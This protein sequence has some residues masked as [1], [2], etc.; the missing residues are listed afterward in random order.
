MAN[1]DA[2]FQLS[3]AQLRDVRNVWFEQLTR[4]ED[5]ILPEKKHNQH[6]FFGNEAFDRLCVDRF[7]GVLEGIRKSGIRTG[8]DMLE[9]VKPDNP[10]DW[11]SL[12]IL[13]DQIPRNCYRD[14]TAAVA[15]TFFDPMAREVALAAMSQGLPEAIPE[16]RW[17]LAYRKWFYLPFVHSEDL[18][19]HVLATRGF[20]MMQKDVYDLAEE[21]DGAEQLEVSNGHELLETSNGNGQLKASNGH[22]QLDYRARAA[23][24]IQANAAR[25]RSTLDAWVDAEKRHLDI[26][27]RFG[28]YPH[29]NVA[30]G[31]VSTAEEREFLENG[32]ETF[33]RPKATVNVE[34]CGAAEVKN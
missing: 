12:I 14:D 31:R 27:K 20:E 13:L 25:S 1:G 19:A 10:L 7:A 4:P 28:R 9:I 8:D 23:K 18:E 15:F 11:V 29:R 16:F 6:W 22:E 17:Q 33:A 30:L 26:L 5:F 3:L 34:G 21:I 24:M 32:G 2:K